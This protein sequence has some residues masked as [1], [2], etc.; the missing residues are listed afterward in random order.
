MERCRTRQER[1]TEGAHRMGTC[2]AVE[3]YLHVRV[4]ML[5]D[6]DMNMHCHHVIV[7]DASIA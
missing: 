5:A 1:D 6:M 2:G 4:V 7:A 3:V